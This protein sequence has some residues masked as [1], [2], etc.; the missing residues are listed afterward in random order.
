MG[1]LMAEYQ[2]NHYE[3][4]PVASVL[5]PRHLRRPVTLLYRFARDADD[6]ADEGNRT[7]E[8]RLS[9]LDGFRQQLAC[10]EQGQTPSMTLF[11][12]MAP[13]IRQYQLPLSYFYDLLDAFTQ[14]VTQTRY[15]NFGEVVQYCRR[16]ANPVGR[17]MLHLFGETDARKMAMSDGICTALQ[18][19]NFLQ[20]VA[21][22]YQKDRIYLPQDE[23]TKYRISEE[24]IARGDAGG[25]WPAMMHHQIQRALKML[26]AGSPLG[27]QLPGRFGLEI[28]LIVLGGE[29][30]L[31][32]LHQVNGNVFDY[33]PTLKATDWPRMLWRALRKK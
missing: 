21:I 8:E 27:M 19:I 10:I 13:V 7:P 22:D 24:Q 15:A 33:R 3:N 12:D 32:K 31:R 1:A 28:R 18:L 9:L 14:D 25:L 29:T 23:L 30:I 5:M 20:D 26:Q 6:F 17:L 16:S 2:V 11:Q 4:F